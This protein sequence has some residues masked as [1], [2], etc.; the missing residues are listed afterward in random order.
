MKKTGAKELADLTKNYRDLMVSQQTLAL[1]TVSV[2]GDPDISYAPF[3]RGDESIF[4]IYISEL[5]AHTRNLSQNPKASVSFIRSETESANLF[6]RERAVFNCTANEIAQ[7]ERN[8]PGLIE[9]LQHK[10]GDIV[11]LLHSLPDFHLF[12]LR[13]TEGRYVA[14]FGR[15]FSIDPKADALI[16]IE[17]E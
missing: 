5:A 10:F 17:P 12:S 7:D 13:P 4:Y 16:P 15:A 2:D 6:A 11:S 9:A 1:A 8:Y 3:V 14:G